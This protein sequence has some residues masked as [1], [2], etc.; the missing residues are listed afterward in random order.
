MCQGCPHIALLQDWEA[1]AKWTLRSYRG[2]APSNADVDQL[3]DKVGGS[4]TRQGGGSCDSHFVCTERFTRQTSG[5]WGR[6]SQRSA[7][8][9]AVRTAHICGLHTFKLHP[10]EFLF[11]MPWALQATAWE[12]PLRDAVAVAAV[13]VSPVRHLHP[14][15]VITNGSVSSSPG[16]TAG[17]AGADLGVE[18]RPD[19][20][21][22]QAAAE[23]ERGRRGVHGAAAS[24]GGCHKCESWFRVSLHVSGAPWAGCSFP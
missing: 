4:C 7:L 18:A 16:R 3:L 9:H 5:A 21:R 22:Q 12:S 2:C 17:P 13:G 20:G 19:P 10:F 15:P 23:H 14:E 11:N 24:Q 8:P 1:M 6:D